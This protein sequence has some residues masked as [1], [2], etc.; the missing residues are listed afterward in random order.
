[1]FDEQILDSYLIKLHA[2]NFYEVRPILDGLRGILLD[3]NLKP[4]EI[5]Y[6]NSRIFNSKIN[7][8]SFI[9]EHISQKDNL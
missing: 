9:Q 2:C 3:E 8:F 4:E 7:L 1:M 5:A 6:C